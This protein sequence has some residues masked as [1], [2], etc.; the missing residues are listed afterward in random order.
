M[1]D[2]TSSGAVTVND[3]I[4]HFVLS[5]LPFGGVGEY[6]SLLF[7]ANISDILQIVTTSAVLCLIILS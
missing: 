6:S 1:I 3:V 5:S 2:G 7:I 4:M